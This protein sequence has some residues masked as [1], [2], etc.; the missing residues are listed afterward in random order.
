VSKLIGLGIPVNNSDVT[1]LIPSTK[2]KLIVH[3]G[4][5][6]YGSREKIEAVFATLAEPKQLVIV[7]GADHFFTGKLERV[8]A[9]IDAW[10]AEMF[11]AAIAQA[12]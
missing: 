12:D 3:G 6:Q 5:D 9:A 1:F 2:P 10:L 4:N 11:P 7:E 8:A